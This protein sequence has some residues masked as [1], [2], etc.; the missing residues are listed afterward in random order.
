MPST[1]YTICRHEDCPIA[2][3]CWTYGRPYDLQGQ[4]YANFIPEVDTEDDFE[5]SRF[6]AYPED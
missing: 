4:S 3:N 1:D 5:C 2:D 6:E